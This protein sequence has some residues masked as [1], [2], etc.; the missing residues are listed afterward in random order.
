MSTE[1][2]NELLERVYGARDGLPTRSLQHRL[3][4]GPPEDW[5][6]GLLGV[7]RRVR[8]GWFDLRADA[9]TASLD[10]IAICRRADAWASDRHRER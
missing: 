2:R 5:P 7:V 10:L 6:P 4:T 9:L 1:K 8:P 3:G